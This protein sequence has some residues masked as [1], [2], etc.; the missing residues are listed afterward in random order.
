MRLLKALDLLLSNCLLCI[1]AC[2]ACFSL[3]GKG[4]ELVPP[5]QQ[6]QQLRK[7]DSLKQQQQSD[8]LERQYIDSLRTYLQGLE[9]E[10]RDSLRRAFLQ[11]ISF[12]NLNFTPEELAKVEALLQLSDSG[13]Q[14]HDDRNLSKMFARPP[15][16]PALSRP[17]WGNP[18]TA[19]FRPL[20]DDW[21]DIDPF[22]HRGGMVPNVPPKSK[23][24]PHNYTRFY[25]GAP[26]YYGTLVQLGYAKEAWPD[27]LQHQKI[28]I[29]LSHLMPKSPYG[30]SPEWLKTANRAKMV[31][32]LLLMFL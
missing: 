23:L 13:S 15:E 31:L 14:P 29:D 20:P 22:K 10:Q 9:V 11:T 6:Q 32:I 1:L 17:R 5:P 28:E 19:V 3:Q 18:P 24:T 12:E 7:P 25:V 27:S 8:S 21:K 4:L 16:D 30:M 2:A 26:G